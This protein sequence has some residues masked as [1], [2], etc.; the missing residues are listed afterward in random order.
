[1]HH[2]LN[3]QTAF[4]L[5]HRSHRAGLLTLG[6]AVSTVGSSASL[7]PSCRWDSLAPPPRAPTS[8]PPRALTR[9]IPT[10]PACLSR[11]TTWGGRTTPPAHTGPRLP[12]TRP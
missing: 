10:I 11:L 12:W 7:P 8:R 1:M 5:T 6:E 9:T 2:V 3:L 4:R